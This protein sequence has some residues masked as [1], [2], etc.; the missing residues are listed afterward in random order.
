MEK[1]ISTHT[2]FVTL[3]R[4][5]LWHVFFLNKINREIKINRWLGSGCWIWVRVY[6]DT[7]PISFNTGYSSQTIKFHMQIFFKKR[8]SYWRT[9]IF[10]PNIF[11]LLFTLSSSNKKYFHCEKNVIERLTKIPHFQSISSVYIG[12]FSCY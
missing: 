5:I 7:I 4:L 6:F 11:L 3:F 12:Q 9:N 2:A 1:Y 8:W 10:V